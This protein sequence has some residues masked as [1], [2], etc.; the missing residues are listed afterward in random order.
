MKKYIDDPKWQGQF[1]HLLSAIGPLL[2]LLVA[3][4]SIDGITMVAILNAIVI[5]WPAITGFLVAAI[6]FVM[7][8]RAKEKNVKTSN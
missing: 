4:L 8:W 7:S 6:P 1:R 5:N 2:G 3:V